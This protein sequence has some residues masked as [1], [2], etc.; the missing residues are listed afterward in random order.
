LTAKKYNIDI[1]IVDMSPSLGAVNQNLFSISNFFIVPMHPDY[2][3]NMAISSLAT[4]LPKWRRWAAAASETGA[5]KDAAY[6]FP[7]SAPKFL[8][9][10]VQKYRPRSGAPSRAFEN[11]IAQLNQ[12]VEK[13]LLPALQKADMLLS[14]EIYSKAG[15]KPSE[16]IL[17]MPD[18]NSLI[19][20]SQTH[21]VPIFELTPEQL[22]Q[23]GVVLER[24][25]ASRDEFKKLFK[26]SADKVIAAID[27]SG[28]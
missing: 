15:I 18:F 12:N 27:A 22:N 13:L 5:L 20:S 28:T 4:V 26:E 8:G 11:W 3:S 9:Y 21:A 2:F 25:I 14:S 16:P 6:P 19:A 23:A 10:I 7:K 24:T 1:V 17:Q